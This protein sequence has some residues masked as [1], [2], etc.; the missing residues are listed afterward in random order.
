MKLTELLLLGEKVLRSEPN[1]EDL[2]IF[3]EYASGF[4]SWFDSRDKDSNEKKEELEKLSRLHVEIMDR[5]Q[6]LKLATAKE[7]QMTR[8][9]AQGLIAYIDVLPKKVS[10][11]RVLK[12]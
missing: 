4:Q 9:K 6:A 5:A 11:K 1:K 12:G 2:A 7:L 8:K 10:M 3:D